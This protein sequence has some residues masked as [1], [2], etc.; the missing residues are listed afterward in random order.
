VEAFLQPQNDAEMKIFVGDVLARAGQS[1][2]PV[3][4]RRLQALAAIG[5]LV[6]LAQQHT[7]V[8]DVAQ[9]EAQIIPL[10][11]VPEMAGRAIELLADI[12]NQQSQQALVQLANASAQPLATRQAAVTALAQNIRKYGTLL[13]SGEIYAQYDLYNLNAGRNRDTHVVLSALLD[14]LEHQGDPPPAV[15]N[16]SGP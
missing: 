5:W 16:T 11:Y 14:V 15:T 9:L 7:G 8:F 4:Q 1:H 6:K 2:V 12:G 3:E 13:T 10:L